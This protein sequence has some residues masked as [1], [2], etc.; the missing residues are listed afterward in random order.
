[1]FSAKGQIKQET[2]MKQAERKL[3]NSSTVE[4]GATFSSETLIDS[5]QIPR[6]Y[7]P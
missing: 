6:R 3:A 2:C 1:M 4:M 5:Q 7:I